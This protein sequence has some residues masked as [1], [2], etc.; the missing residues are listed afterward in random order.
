MGPRTGKLFAVGSVEDYEETRRVGEGFSGSVVQARHRVTGATVAIKFLEDNTTEW[1]LCEAEF[2]DEACRDNPA[3]VPFHGIVREPD[4]E[5]LCIVMEC[6]GP[7][8]RDL[9]EDPMGEGLPYP[10]AKVRD[11]MRQ[12][13]TG[14]KTMHARHI[15]HRHITPA[16]ILF[17]DDRSAAKI[18]GFSY[19]M[20]LSQRPPY[21]LF[22]V[23]LYQA[24]E[25][26]LGKDDYDGVVD[27]WSL[28]C[29]MAELL[30]GY[31]LFADDLGHDPLW[32]MADVLGVPDVQ[33]WP[34]F[35]ATEFS[36]EVA[37]EMP[38]VEGEGTLRTRFHKNVLSESGFQVLR[39]LLRWNPAARMT[40][41]VALKHPWFAPLNDPAPAGI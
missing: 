2:L 3:V 8:L 40:A 26:L 22:G 6:V 28:G 12:L 15:V 9:L 29:V 31:K 19:A 25:V 39:G 16:K 11:I 7:S 17:N 10:E 30:D 34:W 14:V 38:A 27:T 37:Q 36:E 21:S 33:G 41:S 24:P 35:H 5:D 23:P 4:S 18:C 1:V 13:L 32:V 20:H